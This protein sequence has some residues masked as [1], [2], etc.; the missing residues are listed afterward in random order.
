[1][2]MSSLIHLFRLISRVSGI[3]GGKKLQSEEENWGVEC[4]TRPIDRIILELW[5]VK[6]NE[7]N[8]SWGNSRLLNRLPLEGRSWININKWFSDWG[9]GFCESVYEISGNTGC[10]QFVLEFD[11]LNNQNLHWFT[12]HR[13]G[14]PVKTNR[15]N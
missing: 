8:I 13:F 10:I 7:R 15:Y 6:Y 1:M 2:D 5:S 11:N 12:L 4:Y 9:F 14:N 3:W